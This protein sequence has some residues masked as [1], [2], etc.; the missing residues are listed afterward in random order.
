MYFVHHVTRLQSLAGRLHTRE[1]PCILSVP[2]FSVP[3]FAYAFRKDSMLNLSHIPERYSRRPA[4][5][6]V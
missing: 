1:L 2:K 4:V 3:L 5:L 6:R